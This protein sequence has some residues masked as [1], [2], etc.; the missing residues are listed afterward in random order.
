MITDLTTRDWVRYPN[1]TPEEFRCKHTG[2]DGMQK[3]FMDRLQ[4]VR[5]IVGF[6]L[7]INSGYRHPSHPIEAA[8]GHSKGEHTRGLCADIRANSSRVRYK[9]VAAALRAGF[10]RIGI[11]QS[12]VH[13][14]EGGED[15]PPE[16]LWLY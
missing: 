5:D 15:L 9:L 6:P 3:E 1:F 10:T 12:F 11:G 4:H 2:K 16:V 14:G 7:V 8:K 13:L